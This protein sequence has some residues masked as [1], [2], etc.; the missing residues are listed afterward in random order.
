MQL[1]DDETLTVCTDTEFD[2]YKKIYTLNDR[3]QKHGPEYT[4][5]PNSTTYFSISHYI[6]GDISA[7]TLYFNRDGTVNHIMQFMS[8]IGETPTLDEIR[9]YTVMEDEY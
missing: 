6:N 2:G 8:R 3:G 1:S 7:P 5:F 4:Y 9:T